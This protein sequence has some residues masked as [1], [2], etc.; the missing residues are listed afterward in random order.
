[1]DKNTGNQLPASGLPAPGLS[2]AGLF[3]HYLTDEGLA[4][5]W[6]LLDSG[7]YE[8]RA[9]EEAALLCV[10]W[11][12]RA[13]ESGAAA[14][15][16]EELR[17]FAGEVR[18]APH[19]AD[20]PV[21]GADDVHV[22][23]VG[24]VAG[25]LARRAPRPGIEAQHEA[26][27]VW[28]PFEDDLLDHWLRVGADA[29]QSAGQDARGDTRDDAGEGA[30]LLARY[31]RLAAAHTRCTKHLDPKSNPAVLRRA[32]EERVAGREPSPRLAGLLR[33]TV[34]SMVAKRGRPG[35]AEHARLRRD[36]A[37]QA[38]RPAHHDLA[39]L[40]LRRLAPLDVSRGLAD[41][42][43]L[44]G[45]VTPEEAEESGLPAGTVVPAPVRAA[46]TAALSA[47][48]DTLLEHGVISSAEV[49]GE[50][51]VQLI[52]T[53]TSRGY[54][55]A[56]LRTLIAATYRARR[57]RRYPLWWS[58]EHHARISGLP[59]VRAVAPWAADP[60]EEA[61]STL[62]MLGEACVRAFPGAGLPNLHVRA[63]SGLARLAE[64][65]VP[66]A[67]EPL[68]DA[69]SGM[70]DPAVLAAARTAAGLLRGTVYE[71]YHGIDY[72]AVQELADARDRYGFARLCAERAGRPGRPLAS[73]PAVVEQ[74]R[75]LTTSNLATLVVHAGVVPR[76]GW[77]GPARGAFAAATG[78]AATVKSTAYAWRQL[79]FHLALC[80]ADE[81]ARVLTW[82]DGRAARLPARTAARI[83][84]RL[85]DLRLATAAP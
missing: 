19:L 62:R 57:D 85:A 17:P 10:A 5:L 55:D 58:P 44:I 68:A 47:H 77:E 83:A 79:L 66:F 35:S 29:E 76:G 34:A 48:L 37:R 27:T 24:E 71:R 53:H 23:T 80:D 32:L 69:Y 22:R 28:H 1:M 13:G 64:L 49:L 30:A 65:P 16:V 60:V 54:A 25:A 36:Q 74:A 21:P 67:A 8:V 51:A 15:L 78:P 84:A 6:S 81:Q 46:V 56:S 41:V 2:T 4:L 50:V 73:D 43:P 11:L 33:R 7:R 20:R 63:L 26:L 18:F 75:I 61:R 82:I 3:D 40:V 39:A 31:Q 70:A 72:A 38:G 42:G 9:P 45:P 59:W 52:V 12:V 14:A